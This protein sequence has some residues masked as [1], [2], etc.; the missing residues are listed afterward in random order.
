MS[1]EIHN[2]GG[3]GDIRS[4]TYMGR[5]VAVKTAKLPATKDVQKMRRLTPAQKNEQ[6]ENIRK[7]RKVTVNDIFAQT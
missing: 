7:T 4:Q 3:F 2:S 6:I 5:L 1:D